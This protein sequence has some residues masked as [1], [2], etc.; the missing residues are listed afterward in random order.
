MVSRDLMDGHPAG[1]PPL[2]HTANGRK[3]IGR[4]KIVD[5]SAVGQGVVTTNSTDRPIPMPTIA[6][7]LTP[8]S[9][10][11]AAKERLATAI[12]A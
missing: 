6:P 3:G 9:R 5:L 4:P 11:S 12:S 10:R 1:A 7:G 8:A 2:P